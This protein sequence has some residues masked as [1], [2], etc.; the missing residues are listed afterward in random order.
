MKNAVLAVL[1]AAAVSAGSAAFASEAGSSPKI[2]AYYFHGSFRCSTCNAMEQYS[3]EAIGNNFK[4][5][6]DSGGLEFKSVNVEERANEHFVEDYKLFTKALILSQ[7]KGGKEVRS[8]NL[9]K[10]WEYARNKKKFMDYVTAEV[11]AFMKDAA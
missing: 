6:L 4:V 8:K 9:D 11:D 7:I 5:A 1:V 10:I 3:R 2:I